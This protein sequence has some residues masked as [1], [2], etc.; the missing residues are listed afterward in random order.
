MVEP[1][2]YLEKMSAFSRMLRLEG[3]AV[4]PQETADACRILVSLG[5]EDRERMKTALRTVYAKSREEQLIFQRVFDG[6]FISEESMRQQAKEQI[7][8]ANSRS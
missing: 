3:F 1:D 5:F 6:F 8:A 7:H 2:I 4:G